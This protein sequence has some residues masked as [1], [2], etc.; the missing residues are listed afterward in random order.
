MFTPTWVVQKSSCLVGLDT[1]VVVETYWWEVQD[2]WSKNSK[3][4]KLQNSLGSRFGTTR[5]ASSLKQDPMASEHDLEETSFSHQGA[6]GQTVY[7]AFGC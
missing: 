4:R 1:L 6:G 7:G 2:M 5:L 3:R